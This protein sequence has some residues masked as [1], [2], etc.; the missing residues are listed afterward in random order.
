MAKPLLFLANERFDSAEHREAILTALSLVGDV[1]HAVTESR[2]QAVLQQTSQPFAF[3][4]NQP[5]NFNH[6]EMEDLFGRS[7]IEEMVRGAETV[8]KL[9][10]ISAT[11][12][13]GLNT[14][15]VGGNKRSLEQ[16]YHGGGRDS[17]FAR[18]G[19]PGRPES[20]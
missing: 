4:L 6:E 1:F 17:S 2:R 18:D 13:A 16:Q 9:L 19:G 14:G 8:K 11:E 12:P 15:H 7:F 5:S 3:M 10:S 20:A